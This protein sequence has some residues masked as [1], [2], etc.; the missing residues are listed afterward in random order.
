MF[1]F[2]LGEIDLRRQTQVSGLND[3]KRQHVL[4]LG[5]DLMHFGG[6]SCGVHMVEVL[7]MNILKPRE[8]CT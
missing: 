7:A 2:P 3:R 5:P 4:A 6:L 8:R 1:Y